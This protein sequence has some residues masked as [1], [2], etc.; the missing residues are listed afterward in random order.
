MNSRSFLPL[1]LA[2]VVALSPFDTPPPTDT[3]DATSAHASRCAGPLKELNPIELDLSVDDALVAPGAIVNAKVVIHAW[4]D[5]QN[6]RISFAPDGPLAVLGPLQRSIGSMTSGSIQIL[7]LPVRYGDAVPSAV[8]VTAEAN[9][10]IPGQPVMRRQG[11]YTVFRDGRAHTDMGGYVYVEV[12]AIR[13]EAQAGLLT[14]DEAGLEIARVT[15]TPVQID[16]DASRLNT[17]Q[18]FAAGEV[19]TLPRLTVPPSGENAVATLGVEGVAANITVQG[20]V[21]WLD[22]NGTSHPCYGC[23]VQVRDDETIGSE[24]VADAVTN[25]DGLYSFV[26]DNDDGPLAGGRDIFV[27][28]ILENGQVGVR[29]AGG[30]D[31][32]RRESGVTNDVADGA[33]ITENFTFNN[34]GTNS[35]CGILTGASYIAAYAYYLN[36]NAFLPY[37]PLEWPGGSGSFYAADGSHFNIGT[38]DRWDWDV[39]HHEY[40]HYVMDYF[41]IENNPGGPHSSANCDADVRPSK[42]EGNRLA[43]GEGWPTYFGT[44][45]QTVLGL[46][47][48]GVPRVGDSGYADLEDAS[49]TY[50]LE[51][52]FAF[53]GEDNERAVMT[54]FWDLFDNASDGRDNVSVDH[55]TLFNRVKAANPTILSSAW[56]ALRAPLGNSDDLLYGM[57]AADHLIGPDLLAP[58]A[59]SL[60]TP[61]SNRNFSWNSRVG[62]G[63]F[64][65]N[66]F[67]LVF[68]NAATKAKVLTVPG[69]GSPSHM[70]SNGEIAVLGP[71][72]S[73]LWAVEGRNTSSPSTGPYLGENFAITVNRPP[74]ADAGSNQQLE[75]NSH[76]GRSV[77][78]DGTASS[79]PDGDALSYS[80]SATGISFDDPNAAKPTAT[81]PL[82]TTVVTLT[83]ND[84]YQSD[85]DVV[86]I[87]IVDTTAP[88]IA[89]PDGI[90]VE[91]TSHTGVPKTDPAIV[92]F[93]AGASATDACDPSPTI[94]DDAPD[95]FALGTTTVT[96][97]ATDVSLNS[98]QCQADVEVVDTTPP[99]IEVALSRDILWPPNHMLALIEADVTVTDI[100]D[101][102]PTF[103]LTSITSSEP[104]NGTG[105]GDTENDIQDA[106][107]GTADVAF[108]LRSERQG[109]NKPGR[110]YT[111]IYTAMD[112]SGNTASDTVCVRV[113]HDRGANAVAY[114]GF[115]AEG[116]LDPAVSEFVLAVPS[117]AGPT[118]GGSPSTIGVGD[119]VTDGITGDVTL[120]VGET[121][122]LVYAGSIDRHL[123]MV[124]NLQGVVMPTRMALTDFDGDGDRD[125]LFAFSTA[126]VLALKSASTIEDGPVGFRYELQNGLGYL[127][128]SVES[129]TESVVASPTLLAAAWTWD[130]PEETSAALEPGAAEEAPEVITGDVAAGDPVELSD[131]TVENAG[132]W[133]GV[134]A[135]RGA[136]PN[137][138]AGS[139]AIDL[140]LAEEASVELGV[141]DVR[142]ALVRSL[143]RGRFAAGLHTVVWDGRD[144]TGRA[145]PQGIYFIRMA[146]GSRSFV[147]KALLM[148]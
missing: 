76:L 96:F 20:A 107:Y 118:A 31:T 67:D 29:P 60:V 9:G 12:Q 131:A 110:K 73:V 5:L 25:V 82:G 13:A 57:V 7:Q 88:M 147:K 122:P 92:A 72:H 61:T 44:S 90:T 18:R 37:K 84:G 139:T 83:V 71:V 34:N 46:A 143:A 89:C 32:Y 121:Q 70:L 99:D 68:Y 11:L 132:T 69:L 134:T 3:H 127:L 4:A 80:W 113:P 106:D 91:C 108:S 40:G 142:G 146:T 130:V 141:Y 14:P 24:L 104:D 114:S 36:G 1:A 45:A 28:V 33:V 119:V 43:W 50:D 148:P 2:S 38:G 58:A 55:L 21:N 95:D 145:S 48:L 10:V 78:L 105:D 128:L 63:G 129:T 47:S 126:D 136:R 112:M 75:C 30:G 120:D 93:L 115:T 87:E 123:A 85:Q 17:Q 101:P 52:Q 140:S 135:L 102:N 111:I 144:D 64:A 137:P 103:V 77:M 41:N 6:V 19:G 66:S 86:S 22:E 53:G 49:L 98:S 51:N 116:L 65:G 54:T 124:G 56:A 23:W 125:A 133:V 16:Q 27:R 26:V 81:F 138:F 94:D 79:D 59:A 74:V 39:I 15:T 8:V 97:T 109:G 35:A 117:S 62:C 42:S 100:C